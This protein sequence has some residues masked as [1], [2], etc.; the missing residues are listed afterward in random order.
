MN[1][2]KTDYLI[3]FIRFGGEILDL[4]DVIEKVFIFRADFEYQ[5]S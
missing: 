5:I 1:G 2:S 3:S 4:L